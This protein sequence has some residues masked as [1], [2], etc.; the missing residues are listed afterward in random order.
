MGLWDTISFTVMDSGPP[1]SGGFALQRDEATQLVA[2]LQDVLDQLNDM[3][4]EAFLLCHITPPS[5][6][7]GTM[8]Y[9]QAL[10]MNAAGQPAA[11]SYGGGHIDLQLAYVKELIARLRTALGMTEA[12][13]ETQAGAI[14][15]VSKESEGR[16]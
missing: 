11:L 9:Q 16:I 2:R 12:S 4:R 14:G 7:P 3:H 5:Q 6:D 8:I 15:E 1:P 10:T 13:D